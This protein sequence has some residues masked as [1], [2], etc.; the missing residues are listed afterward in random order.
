[1]FLISSLA[2]KLNKSEF[3]FFHRSAKSLGNIIP[4]EPRAIL[5]RHCS[6]VCN[7][8]MVLKLIAPTTHRT[9]FKRCYVFVISLAHL[10]T[11]F[12]S[13]FNVN[14]NEWP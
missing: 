6:T 11:I 12:E 9:H 14:G 4:S 2:A 3:H 5:T 8:L 7:R 1:M 13:F 10:I